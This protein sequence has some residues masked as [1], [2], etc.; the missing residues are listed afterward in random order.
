M[1]ALPGDR[2]EFRKINL[3]IYHQTNVRIID[4]EATVKKPQARDETESIL[5]RYT[6]SRCRRDT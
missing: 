6:A 5:P 1:P 2:N 3:P 4:I